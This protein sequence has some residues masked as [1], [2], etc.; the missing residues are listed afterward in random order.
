M[1]LP[2][3]SR[4]ARSNRPAFYG[5]RQRPLLAMKAI[6]AVNSLRTDCRSGFGLGVRARRLVA[7]AAGRHR[8]AVRAH[9]PAKERVASAAR[10]LG[11]R[12]RPVRRRAELD[13]DLLHLP[14]EDAAMA[15]LGRRGSAVGLS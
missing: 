6:N 1:V 8:R 7:L 14:G 15:R 13:R 3:S 12:L 11:F 2:L 10:R 9:L 5:L 4:E